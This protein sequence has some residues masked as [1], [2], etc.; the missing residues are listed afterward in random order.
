MENP[1]NFVDVT[2]ALHETKDE[3]DSTI[4]GV[5]GV[6]GKRVTA[7]DLMMRNVQRFVG[8]HRGLWKRHR[9]HPLF[10]NMVD[11]TGRRHQEHPTEAMDVQENVPDLT[12][13]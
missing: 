2:D 8:G 10:D 11:F 3:T 4:L 13:W 5:P 1:T 6:P 7:Q 9:S 12:G